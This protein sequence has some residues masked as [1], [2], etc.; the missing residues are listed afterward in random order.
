M[1]PVP[2]VV[3]A[4][5]VRS[6]SAV[7][8]PTAVKSVVAGEPPGRA[9]LRG[10]MWA[11]HLALPLLGLWLLVARPLTDLHWEH[12][13]GHFWLVAA[14]AGLN[15]ALAAVV[16]RAALRRTDGRL[17]LVAC[18]FAAAAGFLG[19]HA[20]ATP[21]VLIER[22]NEGFALASPFGLLVAAAFAL[23]SAVDF[24]PER[25]AALLRRRHL[26]LGGLAALL[27]AWAVDSLL[28]LPPLSKVPVAADNGRY[29]RGL[30]VPGVVL[31]AAAALRYYLVYRRRPAVVLLSVLT[32]WAL[33]AESM[34][35]MVLSR[36]W[37]LSWWEWHLLMAAGFALVA[38]SAYVQYRR[39]GTA[40][41]LFDG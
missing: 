28:G 5:A 27:L 12:H 25:S 8:P 37:H 30:A 22:P 40:A 21:G 33:L 31:Y 4:S 41:G 39:E 19:L 29:L 34:I 23:A 32:A 6:A 17:F 11:F 35:A 13:P 18:A 15:V 10:A 14:V 2:A 36:N 38:Y 20:L 1:E 16:L 7:E 3:P 26:L 24:T 9:W